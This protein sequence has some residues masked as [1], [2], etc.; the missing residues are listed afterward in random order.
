MKGL[1]VCTVVWEGARCLH[2]HSTQR[3]FSCALKTE[4][5]LI[6][7]RHATRVTRFASRMP[8]L[9]VFLLLLV[10][11]P[12]EQA[13]DLHVQLIRLIVRPELAVPTELVPAVRRAVA[14]PSACVPEDS[15]MLSLVNKHHSFLR[16]MQFHFVRHRP[17]FMKRLV[18]VTYNNHTDSFGTCV[19]STF[20]VPPSDFR[21]SNYANMIWAKW[22]IL[23]DALSVAK[24]ALWLDADVLIL[25]NPWSVLGLLGEQAATVE[26][27]IQYQSE[28]PPASD[29][30]NEC[31]QPV[32]CKGC[33][34]INGGQ[35]FLTSEALAAAVY[36]ARP[37]NLSNTD[38]LDQDW[39]DAILHKRSRFS[40][41][42][43]NVSHGN[44]HPP[45]RRWSSCI[46]PVA[47]ASQC[48]TNIAFVKGFIGNNRSWPDSHKALGCKRATHHFNCI[49]S[50]RIKQNM[51]KEYVQKWAKYC[52]NRTAYL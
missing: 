37:Q 30:R 24:Q 21:R 2:A 1:Y 52:G 23:R 11:L 35:L 6:H 15:V 49:P 8:W 46:L 28:P 34:R 39:T 5:E 32:A 13:A 47:F 18:S 10:V 25:R 36:G 4:K 43:G 17:C 3:G 40:Y 33:S 14:R 41:L 12:S 20:V 9:R 42:I 50:R 19:R 51:M 27:D 22:R 31:N 48:W 38:R 16:H 26:Y 29:V 45:P 7:C 44:Y